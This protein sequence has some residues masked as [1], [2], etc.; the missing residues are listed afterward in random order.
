[1]FRLL[2]CVG[3][4]VLIAAILSNVVNSVDLLSCYLILFVV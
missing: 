3:F 2:S 1:M 4:V